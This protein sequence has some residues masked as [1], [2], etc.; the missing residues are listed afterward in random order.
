MYTYISVYASHITELQN[1][2][3]DKVHI[4]RVGAVKNTM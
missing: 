1:S 4:F 2:K 3:E